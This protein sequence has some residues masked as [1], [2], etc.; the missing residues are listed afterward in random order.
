MREMH[1]ANRRGWD[2]MSP[3]WQS[4]V[5]VVEEWRRYP[6][7]PTLALNP[8]EL[9]HLG[10]ISG[11]NVCVL[12][13]GNNLVAFTLAGLGAK[14]TSVDISEV[15][16]S[17]A[18]QRAKELTLN[19]NFIQADVTE[20][21][22]S[23][24]TFD[25]VY[26]GGHVAVWVSDLKKYYSEAGRILKPGGMFMVNEY[27]PFRRIWKEL[28][29][30][31]EIQSGYFERGPFLTDFSKE[32]PSAKLDSLPTYVFHW[33]VSD[34][35]MAMLNAGC[36]LEVLEEIG[37]QLQNWE[38]ETAPVRG[39]PECLLMVGKKRLNL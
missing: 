8:Q 29:D 25:V 38:W 23:G 13:S 18:A 5:D 33:T 35:V 32:I 9:K 1:D 11:K 26:T 15:Q 34:Y 19:I 31:L 3:Y 7:D 28:P 22:M 20:L 6:L 21:P 12:G 4:R 17:I 14:T 37:D 39:L 10:D 24:E 2:T 36:K 30:R 27:H 16:L